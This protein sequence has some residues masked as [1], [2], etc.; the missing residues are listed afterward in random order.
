LRTRLAR[1]IVEREKRI[2]LPIGAYTGIALTGGQVGDIVISSAAQCAAVLALYERFKPK[3]VLTAM[4]LSAEAEAFG[5]EIRMQAGEIPTVIGRRVTTLAEIEE[6]ALP[7]P[8]AARTR[9]H[10]ETV[11]ALSRA[12]DGVPVL[13]GMIGP[14]SLAARIFGVSEALAATMLEPE[15][16][17][18]LLQRVTRFLIEYA[19][20]FRADGAQG[21]LVAEPAAGLLSPDG[22]RAFSAPFVNEIIAAVQN[23][24]FAVVLHNCGATLAHLPAT[25]ESGAEIYHFGAPMDLPQALAFVD[26]EVVLCGNLDP[27]AVF[28]D[29]TPE[30]VRAE[31][32]RLLESVGENPAFVVSSGCDLPPGTPLE[33]VAAFYRV[34][35]EA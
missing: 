29:G 17:E 28:H 12:V 13:G 22:V 4:D 33:N 34:A 20:A 32:L 3:I 6:L 2:A 16:I 27:T 24:G 15:M 21:V 23:E 5:C 7:S 9:V 31:T 30:D 18:A 19:L 1:T 11:R 8:G 14:F 25:L 35:D 10:L 26:G